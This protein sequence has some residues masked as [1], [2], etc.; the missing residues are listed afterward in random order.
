MKRTN[1]AIATVSLT[2]VAAAAYWEFG[3]LT[4]PGELHASHA[5]L[6]ALKG[7]TG[8]VACHGDANV[9]MANACV[10]CHEE[11]ATQAS[12]HKGLHGNLELV[13]LDDCQ[14]CHVEHTGGAV[15][16][17]SPASFRSSG[18]IE[19]EA[20]AHHHIAEFVLIGAHS[21][22]A[23]DACHL[24]ASAIALN[25]GEQRFGGLD[26]TCTSC[27]ED[28]HN[29][30]YGTDC[31][32]CH[33]QTQPFDT[34]AEFV[35]TELF[36]LIDSHAGL[37]CRACH[38]TGSPYELAKLETGAPSVIRQCADCHD[39]PHTTRFINAI[40]SQTNVSASATCSQCHDV[41][42]DSF[43]YPEATLTSAQH[44]ATGFVLE[45]PH[46]L[47]NCSACHEGIGSTAR[48]ASAPQATIQ[49]AALF[50]GRESRDCKV[51]HDDPHLGQFDVPGVATDCLACHDAMH[52]SPSLFDVD[53]HA[54]TAFA[55]TGAHAQ[56]ACAECH[57]DVAGVTQ[58]AGIATDCK[59]CHADPHAQQFALAPLNSDCSLCHTTT[60]F[61]ATTFDLARHATTAFPLRGAHEAVGCRECHTLE[62]AVRQFNAT[63]SDCAACHADVHDGAFDGPRFPAV[64][65]GQTG[66]ARC[67]TESSFRDVT[68]TSDTHAQWTGYPLRGAHAALTCAQCHRP[69]DD[70]RARTVAFQHVTSDCAS[71]HV[72]PHAGQFAAAGATDCARCHTEQSTFAAISFDHQTDSRFPLD[73]TH[74]ALDCS[75]C[76][77]PAALQG[78]AEVIRYRPLGREC[79]DCHGFRFSQGSHAE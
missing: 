51:C 50:P 15:P 48:V 56:V 33:G 49:F 62:N 34:V 5:S 52:F 35:H 78:G 42:H 77:K 21:A 75:Q 36:P 32:S 13:A 67:H 71:C 19:P 12:A 61:A 58:F 30:S 37:S 14:L 63:P 68:W 53:R 76:H 64:V 24:R 17:V 43:F 18:V 72:D 65:A 7:S 54:R 45:S 69:Q 70:Q 1:T 66:C 31:A 16:L 3:R 23:C 47:D 4:S 59:S 74:Q 2:L 20:Y 41:A 38:E 29:N 79:R 40:A 10:A 6:T 73:A 57:N 25:E 28:V 22:L 44:A 9:S 46:D 60:N 11:I 26:Q 39:S 55:L 27:H 8:C